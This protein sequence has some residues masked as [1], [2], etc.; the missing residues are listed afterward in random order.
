[1]RDIVWTV[2][3]IWVVWKIYDVFKQASK[4]KHSNFN[5]AQ[6]Q[7]QNK[8]GEVRIDKQNTHKPHFNPSDAEY[9]DYEEIK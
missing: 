9:V 3:I 1:M 5:K 4:P 8:E 7:Y 6:H 2:I